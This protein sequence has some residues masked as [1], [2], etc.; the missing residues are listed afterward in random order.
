MPLTVVPL[1]VVVPAPFAG[2][3]A[4]SAGCRTTIPRLPR[5]PLLLLELLLELKLVRSQRQP[6]D[7]GAAHGRP[8]EARGSLFLGVLRFMV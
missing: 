5:R 2:L 1:T 8:I 6:S 3:G 7:P 4:G